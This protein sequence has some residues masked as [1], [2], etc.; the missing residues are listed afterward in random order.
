MC[1]ALL[2]AATALGLGGHATAACQ[3]QTIAEYPLSMDRNQALVDASINGK[4]VRFLLDTGSYATINT[5][6][7]AAQ[8]GLT[9]Q[10]INGLD[11][12]SVSGVSETDRANVREFKLG[13]TVGRDVSLMVTINRLKSDKFVGLLGESILAQGDLELDFADKRV[14]VLRPQGCSG[15]QV[16]YWGKAYSV[17]PIAPSNDE[18]ALDVYVNLGGHQVLAT[19]DTG[20]F[21]SIVTPGVAEDAK[22]TLDGSTAANSKIGVFS[23]F[24]IGDETIKNAKLR[25]SDFFAKAKTV[26]INSHVA[27]KADDLPRMLLGA[28]FVRAH[29]IYVARSQ[30]KIYFS[31]NGG[32]IFQ[33]VGPRDEQPSSQKTETSTPPKP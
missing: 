29:R 8:L 14:R 12:Y 4:P 23:N 17:V 2:A 18:D 28:D 30:G 24:T 13:G 19:L 16:V 3:L 11:T 33:T 7:A 5:P 25:I 6:T 27:R 26:P 20:A 10:R 1:A 21:V 15:D 32:P 22:A 31:Y 9:L